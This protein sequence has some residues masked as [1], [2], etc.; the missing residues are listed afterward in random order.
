MVPEPMDVLV[1]HAHPNPESLNRAI[2]D[3]AVRG[4]ERA[5]H[6]VTPI[7]LYGDGF[8]P[9]MTTAERRAYES[10]EPILDEQVRRYAEAVR[11]ADALVFVY[12][13][14]WFGLPAVTKG[15]LE[16]VLV[17]GVAF[18]LDPVTRR[19]RPGLKRVR[20][21]VGITTYGSPRIAMRLAGDP[22][23][24]TIARTVRLACHP[25]CR[26]K[27]LGLHAVDTASAEERAAFLARVER[28]MERL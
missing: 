14:W 17:P 24:R 13:T 1:V 19:V 8:D 27:W 5:G 4:L 16:R 3:A 10:G 15:F 28:E 20:R 7:D 22:G 2:V 11:S 18:E 25:A 23:R 21:L 12:P 6:S 26:R 9:R